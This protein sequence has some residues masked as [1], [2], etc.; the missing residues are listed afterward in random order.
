MARVQRSNMKRIHGVNERI[1][2]EH[3]SEIVQFYAALILNSTASQEPKD[4]G[5]PTPIAWFRIELPSIEFG[6]ANW[7]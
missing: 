4:E 2:V 7:T 3:L 1:G 5:Y 6:G